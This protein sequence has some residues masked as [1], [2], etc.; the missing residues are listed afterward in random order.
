[1]PCCSCFSFLPSLSSHKQWRHGPMSTAQDPT[2]FF[3]SPNS[4]HTTIPPTI[5][6]VCSST[7]TSP[8]HTGRRDIPLQRPINASEIANPV[9]FTLMTSNSMSPHSAEFGSHF[10]RA[11]TIESNEHTDATLQWALCSPSSSR[12]T[13]SHF[14]DLRGSTRLYLDRNIR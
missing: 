5:R 1:M 14:R 2:Q 11:T 6:S 4:P 8:T 3:L 9:Y 10:L 12:D 7:A 13:G